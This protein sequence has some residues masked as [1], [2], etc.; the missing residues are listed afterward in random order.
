MGAWEQVFS[1]KGCWTSC[2]SMRDPWVPRS[3]MKAY[4]WT[5]G[6]P[7]LNMYAP[8]LKHPAAVPNHAWGI[9]DLELFSCAGRA[10]AVGWPSR[11]RG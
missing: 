9:W 4:G 1:C 7:L 3:L 8:G 5:C 10:A 11:R 2:C 6:R